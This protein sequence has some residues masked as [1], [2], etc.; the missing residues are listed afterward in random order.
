MSWETLFQK[1]ELM[2]EQGRERSLKDWIPDTEAGYIWTEGRRLLD[3][4]SND[5]LGLARAGLSLATLE[6]INSTEKDIITSALKRWGAGA[7]RLITGNDPV[8]GL[9][10]REL[11]D[12]KGKEAALVF[13]SGVLANLG[14][15]PA[16]VGRGDAVFSDELNHASLIDGMRLSRAEVVIYPHRDMVALETALQKSVARQKL[17]VSDALFSMDGT[18][19]LLPEL[20]AIKQKYDAWLMLDEAHT[21]GVY[22]NE[23]AGLA[24]A[25]GLVKEVDILMGTLSKA[26]GG[27]GAYIAGDEILIRYLINAARTLIFTTGLPPASVAASFLAVRHS[28]GMNRERQQLLQQAAVFREALTA[29]GLDT[30]GS[31]SQ[32][33][34]VVL[35]SEER[36]LW[37]AAGLRAMGYGGIA[38]R[39]PT[40]AAGASRI[41]FALS[42]VHEWEQLR[43]CLGALLEVM[44]ERE[45]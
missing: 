11:A 30:A 12:L 22:G 23:G 36:T 27:V 20:V 42:A 34:P 9:L 17:I 25:E 19:A 45:D 37:A 29:A 21:G 2:R 38:I 33:V 32:V 15:I 7:S 26:Y 40:V 35:G 43:G 24:H 14:T 39:P 4:A 16:L 10:E 1:L 13:G 28:R 8:Y 3:L 5:Y 41:R 31:V 6:E 18:L 44:D